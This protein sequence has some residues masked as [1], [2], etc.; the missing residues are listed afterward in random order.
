MSANLL[1]LAA[2]VWAAM[3]VGFHVGAHDYGL[4][5]WLNVVVMIVCPVLGVMEARRHGR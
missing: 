1:L 4:G 2:F 3:N 5:F